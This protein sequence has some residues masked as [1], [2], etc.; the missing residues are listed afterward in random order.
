MKT[1]PGQLHR[2]IVGN[3]KRKEDGKGM[4]NLD[5]EAETPVA[6]ADMHLA[7]GVDC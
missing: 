4:A 7:T 6:N 2:Q 1:K 3:S 5:F